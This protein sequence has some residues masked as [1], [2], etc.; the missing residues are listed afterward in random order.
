MKIIKWLGILLLLASMHVG[1]MASIHLESYKGD[2]G[3]KFKNDRAG[4]Y[5]E[6]IGESD[7]LHIP[8]IIYKN[9]THS[10]YKILMVIGSET[11]LYE[12]VTIE[13]VV[14]ENQNKEA[15]TL[16]SH[17]NKITKNIVKDTDIFEV[18]EYYVNFY[19]PDRVDIDFQKNE[20]VYM[21]MKVTLTTTGGEDIRDQVSLRLDR[22]LIEQK[23]SIGRYYDGV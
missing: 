15:L 13:S 14:I 1:C 17:S 9:R 19:L 12:K 21:H 22:K 6:L 18:G 7:R 8:F 23:D 10:P 11:P 20:Y 4:L 5:V 2:F 16:I 3:A